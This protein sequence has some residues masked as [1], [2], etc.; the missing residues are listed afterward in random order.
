MAEKRMFSKIIIDSDCFLDMPLSTQALYFHLS[1]RADDE[2]V[3]NS[4]KKIQR[5]VGCTDDDLRLLIAKSFIIPFESGVIVV[6]HWKIHNTL[7]KDRTKA[8]I[9]IDEK[10]MLQT[11]ENGAYSLVDNQLTTK[12]QPTDNQLTTNCPH[13]LDK[14]RLDK[15]SIDE[16][17]IDNSNSELDC[18][19]TT[20]NIKPAVRHKYGE[21]NN[22]LLSDED[23]EKL[24]AEIP[25]YEDYINRLSSYMASTG[26]SYKN[27]LATMRNWFR[28]DKQEKNDNSNNS[29]P[30][31]ESK[32][33]WEC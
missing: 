18:S 29:M 2:G 22:V 21:Y 27:H 11:D 15:I 30:D 3:I 16:I 17:S 5:A 8:T 13:R 10:S 1:M 9:Y 20:T 7:R 26:K 12:C 14:I 6:K 31:Y 19:P 25:N 28:K 24:K 33:F 32:G 23:M 4:P